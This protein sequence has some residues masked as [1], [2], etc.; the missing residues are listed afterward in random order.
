MEKN[1]FLRDILHLVSDSCSEQEV[2]S[3][4]QDVED[5]F[6]SEWLKEKGRHKL[7]LLWERR[8]TLSTSELFAIGKAISRLKVKHGVWL[9][10]TIIDIK[11]QPQGAHGYITELLVASSITS[12]NSL[13]IP[14]PSNKPGFDVSLEGKGKNGKKILISV[15]NHDVSKH[16]AD[17]I[18]H[19][20]SIRG[21]FKVLI[22]SLGISA[23]L[24]IYLSKSM[25][26]EIHK[27]CIL[28]LHFKVKRLGEYHSKDGVITMIVSALDDFNSRPVM[29]GSELCIIVSPFHRNEHLGF[30]RKLEAASVN[31]NKHLPKDDKTVRML[32]MRIHHAA[33][34]KALNEIANNMLITDEKCGFDQVMLVQPSVARSPDGRS[35]V[36]TCFQ[37]SEL[38]QPTPERNNI[39]VYKDLGRINFD[40]PLGSI[41]MSP[42]EIMLMEGNQKKVR[43]DECYLYQRGD[44]MVMAEKREDG[45]YWGEPSSPASGIHVIPMFEI[46]GHIMGLQAIKPQYEE[47]LLI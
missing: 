8:D 15:K 4:L 9:K 39:S 25:S 6:H 14:A 34:A 44:I 32:Y 43:L 26:K 21:K 11:A 41:S 16:Y 13:T 30:R 37:L 45:S 19:S 29:T 40:F 23:R 3:Y 22:G 1:K 24:V 5:N 18:K 17:F 20:E 7:Q 12:E 47:L 38:K 27:E 10:K 28:M 36:H 31:M 46:D 35:S 33:N 42:S 2:L